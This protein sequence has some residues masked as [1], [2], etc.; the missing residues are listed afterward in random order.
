MSS[1]FHYQARVSP[2]RLI[3]IAQKCDAKRPCTA[4]IKAR[5][6]TECEYEIDG[7]QPGP[8]DRSQFSFWDDHD[9]SYS[10]DAHGPWAVGEMVPGPPTGLPP[11][12]TEIQMPSP[13]IVPPAR[14]LI[15]PPAYNCLLSYTP[16]E[17]RPRTFDK[18]RTHIFVTLPPFSA[19]SSTIFPSIPSQPHVAL[20][21]LGAG[22]FQLSNAALGD[23]NMKLY[24]PRAC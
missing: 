22:Q 13:S 18:I 14:A 16:P 23:L 8:S 1:C 2:D 3:L 15:C 4:C 21:S 11:N 9:P 5:R 10:T 12:V 7:A 19:I 24:V 20:S 17:L 6:A